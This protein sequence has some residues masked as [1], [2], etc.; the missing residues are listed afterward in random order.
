V[1]SQDF[2][3]TFRTWFQK[4]RGTLWFRVTYLVL[5]G[6]LVAQL[7]LLT[8]TAVACLVLLLMPVTVFVVPFWLG[9]RKLKRFAGNALVVFVIAI[10]LAAAMSTQ[11]LLSQ[12]QAVEIRS[13]DFQSSPTMSLANGTV[14]PYKAPPGTPFSFT[15]KLFT[16]NNGTTSQYRVFLNLTVVKG[17]SGFDRPSF[18]MAYT[19]G[20]G[21]SNNTRNGS[22]YKTQLAN[23]TDSIY[24]Y[25]FSVYDGDKNWTYAGP[26]FGPIT[27]SGWTF[28]GFFVYVTTL[29]GVMLLAIIT[30][31]AI[32]FLW[33]Y[34]GR[35]R[36]TRA[37]MMSRAPAIPKGRGKPSAKPEEVPAGKA[38]KAAA[39]TCTNC[40]AD[41]S[42]TDTKC[43]KCG[44]VF[45]D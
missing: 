31:L 13:F 7:Y 25:G 6:L 5:L 3:T 1:T 42:E 21:S 19:P 29:S 26:D 10:L 18:P 33:W 36:E 8:G 30:Y 4:F 23:L 22:L 11:A 45:E 12:N 41:V 14:T 2:W 24:G 16:T 27:A 9:E 28:Y 32:L 39:F 37:R 17:V 38:A 44:A 15:V 35:A 20:N 43:P 40:G 34:M